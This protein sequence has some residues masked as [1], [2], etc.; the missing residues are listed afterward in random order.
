MQL[1]SNTLRQLEV[2]RNQAG[3]LEGS[4]LQLLD[5]TCTAS[6]GAMLRRWLAAPLVQQ[7]L[8]LQRQ[9]AVQVSRMHF[10]P[11]HVPTHV[12]MLPTAELWL[13]PYPATFHAIQSAPDRYVL[14]SVP[15]CISPV[16]PAACSPS[17]H[18]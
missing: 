16:C 13:I 10:A 9:D 6:G 1:T 8:L 11:P 7:A 12:Y 15:G 3:A 14:H 5:R 4:L 17:M 2:L 18:M